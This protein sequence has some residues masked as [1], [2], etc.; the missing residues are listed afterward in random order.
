MTI[1]NTL[2]TIQIYY[3]IRCYTETV[4]EQIIRDIRKCSM[5]GRSCGGDRFMK[6]LE[7]LFE[8]RLRALPWGRPRKN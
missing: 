3:K 5:T 1:K 7:R 6:K 4:D 2:E 8:R